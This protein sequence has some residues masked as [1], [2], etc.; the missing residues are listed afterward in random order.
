M[1]CCLEMLEIKKLL[2]CMCD[3]VKNCHPCL[4]IHIVNDQTWI[5]LGIEEKIG[6]PRQVGDILCTQLA[7][8]NWASQEEIMR[9]LCCSRLLLDHL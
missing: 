4:S 6:F 3:V 7:V 5:A 1:M 9:T 2:N 8:V